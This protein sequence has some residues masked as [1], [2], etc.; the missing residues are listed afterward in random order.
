MTESPPGRRI[1]IAIVTGPVGEAIQRWREEHDPEQALRIP[2]HATL[3][4]W[5]PALDP[6]VLGEQVRHAFPET[7]PVRLGI[8]KVFDNRERTIYLPVEE[9]EGLD[10][11]RDRLYDGRFAVL[12]KD[13]DWEWHVT[14]VRRTRSRDLDPLLAA[15]RSLPAGAE[16]TIDTVGYMELRD[17]QY[18]P[19]ATWKIRTAT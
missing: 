16:W 7:V 8:A 19:L 1:L 18:E 12:P 2:P 4:Y 15:A 11:A 5:A 17:G 6:A 10:R 14:C 9:T 3:C 13:R